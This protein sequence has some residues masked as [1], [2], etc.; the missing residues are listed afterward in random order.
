MSA[1]AHLRTGAFEI[2]GMV[3]VFVEKSLKA[4]TNH[5]RAVVAKTLAESVELMDEI[6]GGTNAEHLI[7]IDGACH[8]GFPVFSCVFYLGHFFTN[9]IS[10]L[11][12]GSRCRSS[13]FLDSRASHVTRFAR[14][15]LN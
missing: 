2:L 14:R 9:V 6:F 1:S 8:K 12:N 13:G 4:V 3:V 10:H 15:S 11:S 5:F 7:A